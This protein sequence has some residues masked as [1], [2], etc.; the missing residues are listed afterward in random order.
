MP[1]CHI[2]EVTKF[3]ISDPRAFLNWR[4]KAMATYLRRR[5]HRWCPQ[6][7]M[8]LSSL[9]TV[10]LWSFQQIYEI[11]DLF[12]LHLQK[13]WTKFSKNACPTKYRGGRLKN[14]APTITNSKKNKCV[15]QKLYWRSENLKNIFS[16]HQFFLKAKETIC[17][18]IMYYISK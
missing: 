7:T 4:W 14:V 17:R 12:Y 9:Q 6:T 13:F 8:N 18:T 11:F 15:H 1:A 10:G 16:C 3:P 2:S 5:W